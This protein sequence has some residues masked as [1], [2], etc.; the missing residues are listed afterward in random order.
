MVNKMIGFNNRGFAGKTP[1][2]RAEEAEAE[3]L[4]IIR[5]KYEDDFAVWANEFELHIE[6]TARQ[7][8]KAASKINSFAYL[9]ADWF[10]FVVASFALLCF[11][12]GWCS[13]DVYASATDRSITKAVGSL[14]HRFIFGVYAPYNY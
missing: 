8:A 2:E 3:R 14:L 11:V 12:L 9:N 5:A 13:H 6:A 4:A 1:Q 10:Y 7:T